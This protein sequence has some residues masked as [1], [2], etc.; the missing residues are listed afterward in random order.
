MKP[1]A[2]LYLCAMTFG[3]IAGSISHSVPEMLLLVI[4]AFVWRLVG[5]W[6]GR[7]EKEA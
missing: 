4:A 5:E 3:Y 7:M 6:K 2:A 1:Q